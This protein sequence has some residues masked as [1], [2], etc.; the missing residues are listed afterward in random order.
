MLSGKRFRLKAE[1]I[2]IE[3]KGDKR[4]A[5]HVPAGS[6]ITIESGPRPDDRR[7]LD[8]RWDG[9][10]LVMFADDIQQRGEQVDEV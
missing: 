2:A 3:T 9:R 1:T 10:K 8:I 6:V 5:L 7:M 4:T